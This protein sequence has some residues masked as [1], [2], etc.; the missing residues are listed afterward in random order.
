MTPEALDLLGEGIVYDPANGSVLLRR[1]EYH[2]LL[3]L[4]GGTV[5]LAR[6]WWAI[7]P[8]IHGLRM[9]RITLR[10]A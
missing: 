6:K 7:T 9:V 8:H 3:E 5:F 1:R 2:R 4:T 10:A